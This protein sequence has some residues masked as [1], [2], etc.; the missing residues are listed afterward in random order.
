MF[1][2]KEIREKKKNYNIKISVMKMKLLTQQDDA[3][4]KFGN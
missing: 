2:W 3:T 1:L 4:V